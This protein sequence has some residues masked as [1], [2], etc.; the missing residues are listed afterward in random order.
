MQIK[1]IDLFQE[2]IPL[3]HPFVISKNIFNHVYPIIVRIETMDGIIGWGE[4]P[5]LETP[6]YVPETF[7]TTWLMVQKFFIPS[8]INSTI[9][10]P[11]DFV[12][13]TSWIQGNN[14]GR[15]GLDAAIW[16]IFA[17]MEKKSLSSY[18][19]GIRR[20]VD[21]GCSEGLQKDPNILLD[22]IRKRVNQRY[23]RIKIKI[24]PSQDIDVVRQIRSAFPHLKLMLDANSAYSLDDREIFDQLD[25]FQLMMI[26]QPLGNGDILDH[27]YLQEIIRTPICLDESIHTLEDARLAIRLNACKIINVKPPRV[28]GPSTVVEIHNYC[29]N[30]QIPLWVGGMIE[31]G[32][33]R[34]LNLAIASLPNFTLPGDISPP[35][36]ILEEDIIEQ[37]FVVNE[38]GTIDVPSGPGLGVQVK[39]DILDKYCNRRETY[40]SNND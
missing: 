28:G 20:K 34:A 35:T 37:K 33:G 40:W 12:R 21:A 24:A 22:R 13:E 25:Q 11:A 5:N 36:D 31:T 15:A 27:A 17:K 14:L 23:K 8:I 9:N 7:E 26:E 10:S 18:L 38:D 4:S 3:M 32:I 6:W 1:K 29:K 19:G 30:H 16:D 39:R 2:K